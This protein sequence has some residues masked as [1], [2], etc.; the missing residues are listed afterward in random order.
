MCPL[1][2]APPSSEPDL[3]R[4][5]K[6]SARPSPGVVT[7]PPAALPRQ[8]PGGRPVF[9]E[10][11]PCLRDV[12]GEIALEFGADAASIWLRESNG[13]A[14]CVFHDS[15][16]LGSGEASTGF[17]NEYRVAES[18]SLQSLPRTFLP[19]VLR[20]CAGNPMLRQFWEPFTSGHIETA[21]AIP[22][23]RS[24]RGREEISGW[25]LLLHH[26]SREFPSGDIKRAAIRMRQLGLAIRVAR[27]AAAAR[28]SAI[29]A[30]RNRI[31]RELHDTVAQGLAAILFHIENGQ[32]LLHD[33]ETDALAALEQAREVA[34]ESLA[35]GRRAIWALSPRALES[36]D[37]PSALEGLVRHMVAGS[38][39]VAEF[40]LRGAV[41][42]L[43]VEIETNLLRIIQEAVTNAL[44]H[45]R[46][47]AIRVRLAGAGDFVKVS[48]ED[49]GCGF[50]LR[51]AA[52]GD[53]FG[54]IG[55]R[56]RAESLSGKLLISS[57]PARGTRVLVKIPISKR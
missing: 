19:V 37:L 21:L 42:A 2:P 6:E 35:E 52:S 39:I 56:E 8:Q 48:I 40:K 5:E 26:R 46:P 47:R 55:M 34:H 36:S 29:V 10:L 53:G 14:R 16:R 24:V 38:G 17:K 22:I 18:V 54:L 20:D 33:A 44:R 27:V 23:P 41:P 31:A 1:T 32:A 51:D 11:S 9:G 50:S 43:T 30:E 12:V 45:A 25:C 13:A 3:A 57:H 7:N 49:D 15:G 4:Q 28:E